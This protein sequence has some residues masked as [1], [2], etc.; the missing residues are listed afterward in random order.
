MKKILF[1]IA[2][3]NGGGAERALSNITLAM[4][5][6]VQID[7]L[8]NCEEPE[9]DYQHRGNVISIT[10]LNKRKFRIP[11]PIRTCFLGYFK[12][13]KLKKTGN[14][15]A[16]ISFMDKSNIMNVLTGNTKCKVILS[17]RITLS[18]T[19]VRKLR[20]LLTKVLFCRAD[21][22]VA[23]SKGVEYDLVKYF[24]IPQNKLLT[25]YNG[26]NINAIQKMSNEKP[27]INFKE[28]FFCFLNTG[29]LEE[30][31]GQWHLIR[32][33]GEVVKMHPECRLI[34]CGQGPYLGMLKQIIECRKLQEY[35]I[36]LGFVR[37][38]YAISKRCDA[39]VF[40]SMYEGLPNALIENMICGLPIIATDFKSGAREILAPDTDYRYQVR[41]NIELAQYGIITPVCSGNKKLGNEGLEKEEKLLADAML[42]IVED[43]ELR[44]YY[45]E[46]SERRAKD[47]AVEKQVIQW[48]E[49]LD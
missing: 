15:N 26:Y 32:A 29:R 8:V 10:T 14:Y 11:Y 38:P 18:K 42:R 37:N 23:V 20:K 49:L 2:R 30:L 22:V 41:D 16:C 24:N 48:L 33:F 4:P 17:E 35:V 12:L 1:F 43:H 47:F 3:L 44:R 46:Q 27:D 34:I 21:K 28:E 7:I 6:D 31:K 45:S 19:K 13:R 9:K 40:P 5:D 25:I 36:F 39:F